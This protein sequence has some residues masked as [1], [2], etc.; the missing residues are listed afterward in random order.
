MTSKDYSKG[1]IYKIEPVNGEEGDIYIGSTCKELLSQ[2][3]TAHRS[4]YKRWKEGVRSK[5]MSFD[6]FDKYGIENCV[7]VLIE[8][9][10]AKC[11]DELYARE[12]Y[13]IKSLKC[14]NK[15]I[16]LRTPKEYRLENKDNEM[17]RHHDYYINQIDKI[18]AYNEAH[19]ESKK[20]YNAVYCQEHKEEISLQKSSYHKENKD[21][22]NLRRRAP[23]VCICS[24]EITKAEKARHEKTIK[25]QNFL[26]TTK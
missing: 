21:K 8:L 15:Y 12:Q 22:I 13:Y 2:R 17:L 3:M 23:Y 6:L 5:V 10:D 4:D 26:K 18:K 9:V 25:H 20:M 19:K 16:P 24:S 14:V 11:K 7:I 1:K